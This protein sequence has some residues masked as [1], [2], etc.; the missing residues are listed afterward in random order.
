MRN[1]EIMIQI[2]LAQ[3][4]DALEL[5]KLNDLFNGKDSN[6]VDAI[7]KSLEENEREIV[8]VAAEIG[9]NAGKLVGFCCGQIIKSM[10]YSI[11]Y[12][13]I[14]EFCVTEE[15][16]EDIEEIEEYRCQDI[17]KQLI[18]FIELEF[19]KRGVNHLHHIIG[20]DN[21][22]SQEL[23]CSLGYIDSSESSYGSSFIKVFEKQ[24]K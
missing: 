21:A 17:G 23:F 18:E 5:K 8:C 24:T 7:K 6:V 12:G 14:T 2:R 3:S 11:L 9:Q 13:D 22:L 4:S 10:C 1:G 20:K 15:V 19:D 16:T